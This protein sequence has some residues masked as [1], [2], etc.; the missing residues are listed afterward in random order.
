MAGTMCYMISFNSLKMPPFL[1]ISVSFILHS[2]HCSQISASDF[3]L[4][5]IPS[6]PCKSVLIKVSRLIFLQYNS[7]TPRDFSLNRTKTMLFCLT[8]KVINSSAS[9]IFIPYLPNINLQLTPSLLCCSALSSLFIPTPHSFLPPILQSPSQAP[10][11]PE[12]SQFPIFST[13]SLEL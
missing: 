9:I 10:G 1:S 4:V 11:L 3:Q 7:K 5:S 6:L 2:S 8:L 12:L 13:S